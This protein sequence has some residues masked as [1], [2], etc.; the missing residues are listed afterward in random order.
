[1]TLA[2]Q[3]D[4]PMRTVALSVLFYAACSSTL[5]LI[6]KAGSN[7]Y[8]LKSFGFCLFQVCLEVE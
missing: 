1:M 4:L 2:D 6:N 3:T 8:S 7:E 5:L